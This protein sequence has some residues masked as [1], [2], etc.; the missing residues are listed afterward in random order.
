MQI[1]SKLLRRLRAFKSDEK[2]YVNVEVMIIFPMIVWIFGASW[3]FFD[4]FR[5]Q[6][7]NQK[8]AYTIGDM[9]SRETNFISRDYIDNTYQLFN[10]LTKSDGDETAIR[11]TVIRWNDNQS[12]YEVDWSEVRGGEVSLSTLEVRD[13]TDLLPVMSHNERIILVETWETYSPVIQAGLPL[14]D[15]TTF[16][17]TRPRFA[18]QVKFEPSA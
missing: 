7:V 14:T 15:I 16:S 18:P 5:Q 2:G 3:V 9:L 17:F 12:Q 8:A 4:V 10:F 6:N 1:A 11:V 13:W